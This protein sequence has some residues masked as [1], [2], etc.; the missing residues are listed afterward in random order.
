MAE[1]EQV[2][3]WDSDGIV[4]IVKAS[5]K[6]VQVME[7]RMVTLAAIHYRR[8]NTVPRGGLKEPDT[9]W[10]SKVRKQLSGQ[11]ST[12]FLISSDRC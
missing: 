3:R 10:K 6:E 4:H 5:L 8:R 1:L 2:H 12:F 11:I 9:K 7:S